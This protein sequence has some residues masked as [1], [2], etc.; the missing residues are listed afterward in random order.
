MPG[1]TPTIVIQNHP[2]VIL[3]V[4]Q[5]LSKEIPDQVRNDTNHCHPERDSGSLSKEI[6]DQVRNDT[7]G[8]RNDT[9]GARNDTLI[10]GDY[11]LNSFTFCDRASIEV[12]LSCT[13]F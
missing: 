10:G 1:M 5:D 11:S 3:N 2:P 12:V 9:L 8:A 13:D 7:L 4:I 6:P